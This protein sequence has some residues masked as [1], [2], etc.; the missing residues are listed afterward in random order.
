MSMCWRP[1]VECVLRYNV[2][3]FLARGYAPTLILIPLPVLT[4]V[5]SYAK[6]GTEASTDVRVWWHESGRVL[7][8]F[9]V[10]PGTLPL[11]NTATISL[12]L[13]TL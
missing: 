13:Y 9:D 11:P 7:P 3:F 10:T 5:C 4:L 8:G 1:V 6:R 2:F 12:A